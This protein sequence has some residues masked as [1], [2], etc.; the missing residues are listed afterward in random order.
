VPDLVGLTIA[1]EPAAWAR[2]RMRD[3]RNG[4]DKGVGPGRGAGVL[5]LSINYSP[6]RQ[7]PLNAARTHRREAWGLVRAYAA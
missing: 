1:D 5:D 4:G 7:A 6:K 3:R 2:R